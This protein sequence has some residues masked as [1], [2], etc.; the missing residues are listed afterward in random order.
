M[1]HKNQYMQLFDSTT[2]VYHNPL[3][4]GSQ[5]TL[6]AKMQLQSGPARVGF[7]WYIVRDQGIS[8]RG[9]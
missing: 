9:S 5:V 1:Y 2:F 6:L 7:R 8:Y 3:F 4:C